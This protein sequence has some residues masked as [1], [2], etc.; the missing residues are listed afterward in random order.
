MIRTIVEDVSFKLGKYKSSDDPLKGLIGIKEPIKKI[1]NLLSRGDV[2]MIGIWGMVGMGKTTLATILFRRLHDRFE[3]RCFLMNVR[4]RCA[5]HG[6][7]HLRQNLLNELHD[8]GAIDQSLEYPTPFVVRT[9]TRKRFP[10]QKVLIVLDDVDSSDNLETLVKGYEKLHLGSRIIVTTRNKQVL[11]NVPHEIYELD[12]S[13]FLEQLLHLDG[14]RDQEPH[15][16]D[17]EMLSERA[18]SYPYGKQLSLKRRET[19]FRRCL[20]YIFKALRRSYE[21][22]DDTEKDIFLDIA[23]FLNKF[24]RDEVESLLD[25]E[26]SSAKIRV[27][28]SLIDKSL[29][30]TDQGAHDQIVWMNELIQKVGFAIV[31]E[32]HEQPGNRTRL[33]IADDIHHV[34]ETASVSENDLIFCTI[35]CCFS[36]F[37]LMIFAMLAY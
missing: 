34:L 37:L 10:D 12:C 4:E 25:D 3:G 26:G 22:L 17:D 33:W 13:E 16:T 18:A 1:E 35:R 15:A 23:C 11:M 5:R 29:V 14:L 32:E 20:S 27:L 30:T 6:I 19:A 28:S 8:E 9:C 36:Y 31:L 7:H 21:A 2:S 24:K